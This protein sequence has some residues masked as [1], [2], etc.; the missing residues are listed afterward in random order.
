[1]TYTP[2]V[3][4][5]TQTV[6]FTQPLIENNFGFLQASIGQEH[7]FDVTDPTKTYHKQ[8]SM[9]NY[10]GNGGND[11]AALPM[12]TDGMF[13]VLNSGARFFD[14]TNVSRL[15]EGS[16][17]SSGYQW[18]GQ[19]LL[20]WGPK[21]TGSVTGSVTFPIAF[22][23]ACFMVVTTPFYG[24]S[25]PNSPTTAH[26]QKQSSPLTPSK[27]G[28]NFVFQGSANVTGFYWMAIGN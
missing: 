28:F 7:N 9:P 21:T 10:S 6:A 16:A 4:Q 25:D 5:A 19:V 26:V 1:M 15:S 3:P 23:T 20:Q 13:Y 24:A 12:F 8:A 2:N 14:G 22:S 18:I 17:A 27:T 11:P